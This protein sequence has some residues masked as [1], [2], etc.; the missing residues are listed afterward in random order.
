MAEG[1]MAELIRFADNENSVTVR[2]LSGTTAG[3]EGCL[4]AEIV[5]ASEF[6][7]GHLKEVYLL[8]DDLEQWAEVLDRLASGRSAVWM[9]DGRN[10]E[11][12]ITPQGPYLSQ[13]QT[14]NAVEI[15]VRDVS[16]SLTS[17]CILVRLADGWVEDQRRR[18]AQVRSS[19][20]LSE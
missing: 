15:A 10:P 1:Q 17:V 20:Q 19:W 14:L 4:E 8:E 7:N 11:I 5:A 16:V 6:A 18:L 2:V 9:D 12:T 13:G 3:P